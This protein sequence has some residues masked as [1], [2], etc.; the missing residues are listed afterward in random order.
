MNNLPAPELKPVI[1][2]ETVAIRNRYATLIAEFE[3]RQRELMEAELAP[4]IQRCAENGE[5]SMQ[6]HGYD[7][8]STCRHCGYAEWQD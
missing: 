4:L 5:H 6:Y 7:W 2:A 8:P 1:Q 3:K